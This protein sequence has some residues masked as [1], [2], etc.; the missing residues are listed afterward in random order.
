MGEGMTKVTKSNGG[1]GMMDQQ[2]RV[3]LRVDLDWDVLIS[4]V[5][6]LLFGKKNWVYGSKVSEDLVMNRGPGIKRLQRF[7]NS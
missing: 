1:K 3:D 4:G 6:G 7:L 5:L 2:K